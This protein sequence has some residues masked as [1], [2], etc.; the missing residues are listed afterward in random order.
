MSGSHEESGLVYC[1]L[2]CKLKYD[3]IIIICQLSTPYI[4]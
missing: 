3:N 2:Y 4:D 1:K